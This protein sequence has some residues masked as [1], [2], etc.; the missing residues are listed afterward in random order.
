MSLTK[1]PDDMYRSRNYHKIC[2]ELR[3]IFEDVSVC[4]WT[5]CQ[6]DSIATVQGADMKLYRC[7]VQIK[8]KVEV[9]NE[10]GPSKGAR[11]RG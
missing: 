5:V 6:R 11:C 10:C 8:I 2:F 3:F 7:V 1:S 4:L 9:E